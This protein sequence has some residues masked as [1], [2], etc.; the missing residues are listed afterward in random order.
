M[1]LWFTL[2]WAFLWN[3]VGATLGLIPI[4]IVFLISKFVAK[5]IGVLNAARRF[6]K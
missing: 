1:T 4:G 6:F 3:L 2:L 5:V